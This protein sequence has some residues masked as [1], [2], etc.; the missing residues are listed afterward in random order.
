VFA[1]KSYDQGVEQQ[2]GEM[3]EKFFS[4]KITI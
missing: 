1:L 2:P 4:L 3:I